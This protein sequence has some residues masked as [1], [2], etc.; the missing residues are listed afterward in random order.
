MTMMGIIIGIVSVVTV[1]SIGEGVKHQVVA[2]I[3][4]LGRDLITIRPGQI[5]SRDKNGTINGVN[6]FA[7]YTATGA[8]SEADVQT[9]AGVNG[10]KRAVP[11]SI[12]AGSLTFDNKRY[13]G[14]TVIGTTPDLPILL[15]QKVAY[16]DFFTG[17]DSNQ[18]GAIIG[19]R[20]ARDVFGQ[21]VPLGQSFD[22]LGQTFVVRGVFDEFKTSPLS[23]ETD[24]NHAVF[25]PYQVAQELTEDKSKI[26]EILAQAQPG[27]S[28]AEADKTAA[29]IT[30]NLRAAHGNQEDFTVLKHGDSLSVTSNILNLLTRLIAGI[31]AISLLVGGIG[32]MNVM[33]VSVTE[34][35]QEIGIRKAVGATSR[36]IMNQFMVEA[37]V[38]SVV[39]G[40]IGVIVSLV[41][42]GVLRIF[43][44]LQPIINWQ[45]VALAVGVSLVVGIIFGTAPAL[46]AA[47]KDPIEALRNE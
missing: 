23:L 42:N 45:V 8:L 35:M 43:T 5:V 31:A 7:G 12:L 10:V 21:D 18:N 11:L 29:A 27:S 13:P 36:Q 40:I 44:D 26:Y 4:H 28:Q 22:F 33:L 20:V 41:I 32:I 34:R 25:V 47:R 15:N 14:L 39:G 17:S 30:T 37:T 24:F 1:V 3:N 46:K 19:T 16:G 9:I 2:Q 38:L 6:L